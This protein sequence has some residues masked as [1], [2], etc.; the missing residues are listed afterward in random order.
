MPK[1]EAQESFKTALTN[2]EDIFLTVDF[3]R[4]ADKYDLSFTLGHEV[5]HIAARHCLRW[6]KIHTHTKLNPAFTKSM[7][8]I[9]MDY[10]CNSTILSIYAKHG[11]HRNYHASRTRITIQELCDHLSGVKGKGEGPFFWVDDTCLDSTPEE[12]C[13]RLIAV[14]LSNNNPPGG[15]GLDSQDGHLDEGKEGVSNNA[16]MRAV[17]QAKMMGGRSSV[18]GFV[19]EMIG[20]LMDPKITLADYYIAETYRV[21][22][23]RCGG[24][25]NDFHRSRRRFATNEVFIPRK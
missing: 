6:G 18:P 24:T 23:S 14:A 25:H 10:L 21:M 7:L 4:N 12:I 16:I 22:S 17:E 19:D 5:H 1:D 13:E 8:N 9:A 20:Q 15:P 11:N 2:G 3:L